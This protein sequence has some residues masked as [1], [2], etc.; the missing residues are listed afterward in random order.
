MSQGAGGGS[1]DSGDGGDKGGRRAGRE[2]VRQAQLKQA[3]ADRRRKQLTITAAVVG[4]IAIAVG[5]GLLV[6]NNKASSNNA[7]RSAFGAGV[8][9]SAP[10]GV[11]VSPASVQNPG[12]IVYGKTD[13]KVTLQVWEDV[14]CPFC[15][16]AEDMWG[17]IY[18]Q[19]TDQGK[20]KVEY[21]LVDLIDRNGAG[22]GSLVGGNALACAQDVGSA[23]FE[24]FHNLL[25]KDQPSETTDPYGST[26]NLLNLAG[27][28]AGLRG[29]AFDACVKGGKY[30]PWVKAN[31]D[32]LSTL[33]GGSVG[34]PDFYIDGTSFPL[35]DSTVVPATQQQADFKAALD[36]AIAKKG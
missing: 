31:Y 14:R 20:I 30:A 32:A 10:A 9:F 26:D 24:S 18:R 35:K 28:V 33:L 15:K 1:R 4:V 8:P 21:H 25:Y 27:Q 22:Q 13:A 19:Y 16:Q 11:S 23:Q 17:D 2:Q 6:Q 36:V 34:T 5:I 7:T 12:G 29:T 3:A